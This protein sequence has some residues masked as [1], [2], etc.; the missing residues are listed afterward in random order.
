MSGLYNGCLFFAFSGAICG[1]YYAGLQAAASSWGMTSSMN[2]ND[3]E[4]FEEKERIFRPTKLDKGISY[5]EVE[6]SAR[7]VM[8]YYM[9]YKRNQLGMETALNKL[10]L[11]ES[12]LPKIQA[13][14]FHELMK[15][16]E[17]TE[18]IRMCKLAARASMERKESGRAYYG[19]T[20]Y[21]EMNPDLQK[22]LV[23]WQEDDE[24]RFSWGL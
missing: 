24:P 22:P 12:Y 10:D 18:L 15:A 16:N 3:S 2:V 5:K 8:N 11:I 7:Q 21:P 20:D 13:P 1:G 17:A 14:N 23:M 19:R 4:V 9:G 6:D